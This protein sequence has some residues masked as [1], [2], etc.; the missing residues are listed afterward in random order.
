MRA[1]CVSVCEREREVEAET[2]TERGTA[3]TSPDNSIEDSKHTPRCAPPLDQSRA[4][5]CAF[6]SLFFFPAF[7]RTFGQAIYKRYKHK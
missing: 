1:V 3:A 4:A 6:H 7:F 2:E 5:L